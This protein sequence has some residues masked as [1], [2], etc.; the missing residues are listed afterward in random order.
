MV[1]N[2][3]GSPDRSETIV[4]ALG[5]SKRNGEFLNRERD[6][7]PVAPV[8]VLT[9][10][11]RLWSPWEVVKVTENFSAVKGIRSPSHPF[12]SHVRTTSNTPAKP[13]DAELK[14]KLFSF[15]VPLS[16]SHENQGLKLY[17]ICLDRESARM[18]RRTHRSKT[19]LLL[20]HNSES[21]RTRN[22]IAKRVPS[23]LP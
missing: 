13:C 18:L 7:F 23:S 5:S 6:T 21:K 22:S 1:G 15:P 10:P 16:S 9:D 11:K 20:G 3:R 17:C 4:V 14:S 12:H 8:A 2:P 19:V